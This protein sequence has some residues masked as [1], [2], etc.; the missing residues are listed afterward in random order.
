MIFL[1]FPFAIMN[2]RMAFH[3]RNSLCEGGRVT[4][5]HSPA[6]PLLLHMAFCFR[7]SLCDGGSVICL[8]L[9][10]TGTSIINT[11][12]AFCFWNSLYGGPH[13]LSAIA[14]HLQFHY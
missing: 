4:C 3:F 9:P 14:I 2:T 11:H 13:D 5:L 10:F 12:K 6:I 8:P 1:P 7:N